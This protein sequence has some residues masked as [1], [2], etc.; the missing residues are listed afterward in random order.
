MTLVPVTIP[1]RANHVLPVDYL[2]CAA[3]R[4]RFVGGLIVDVAPDLLYSHRSSRGAGV[5]AEPSV[6]GDQICILDQQLLFTTIAQ[7]E[8][9]SSTYIY[10]CSLEKKGPGMGKK[11]MAV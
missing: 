8:A 5:Q 4:F 7:P 9:D 2:F 6:A 1:E 10:Q 11:V 3:Y